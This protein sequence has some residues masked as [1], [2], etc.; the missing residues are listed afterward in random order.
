M[1]KHSKICWKTFSYKNRFARNLFLSVFLCVSLCLCGEES[2]SQDYRNPSLSPEKRAADLVSRMTL[3]EKLM[4]LQNCWDMKKLTDYRIG[5]FTLVPFEKDNSRPLE[6]YV[7]TSNAVQKKIIE[8]SRL[9]IPVI[10]HDEALHGFSKEGATCFPHSIALAATWDVDLM[11]RVAG[12]IAQESR[13]SGCRQV[14]APVINIGNDPRW[15]RTQETYGEDPYL[16]A[17][18]GATYCKAFT[19]EGIVTTPKHFV[20]N[21]GDGGRDSNPVHFSERLLREIYFPPFEACIKEGGA[22]S[23]MPSFNSLD[24]R[25]CNANRWLL[26]DIL[27]KEWGFKGFTV[28]DYDALHEIMIYHHTAANLKEAAAQALNAGLD[29]EVPETRVY[30]Q[31][32]TDAVKE[33]LVP[34]SAI[35]EAVRRRLEVKFRIGLFENPYAPDIADGIKVFNT[36]EHHSLSLQAEREAIVLLKNEKNTL[37]LRKD[38]KAVAVIGAKADVAQLGNYSRPGNGKV[39][40]LAGI[41]KAVSPSTK[42]VYEK[43]ADLVEYRLPLIP[44]EYFSHVENGKT[45]KGVKVEFFNNMELSGDPVLIRTD[46]AINF[47]VG[48]APDPKVNSDFFSVRWSG[49]LRSPVTGKLNLSITT[50]DGVR[51]FFNGRKLIESWEDRFSSTDQVSVELVK[52]RDYDFTM[53]IYENKWEAKAFLGWDYGLDTVENAKIAKAVAAAKTAGAAVIVTSIVEGEF[54]DRCDLNLPGYQ[55]KL[56]EAVTATGVPTVVVLVGGSAITMSNWLDDTPA[57]LDAWYGGDEGGTAVAE[58]LF[59]DCNPSGKLPITFPRAASQLPLVYNH[60]PSGRGYDYTFMSAVPLFPFGHGLSYTQFEYSN[61]RFSGKTIRPDG[62]VTVS[63]DVRNTGKVKGDEVVQLYL[64]DVVGSVSR[65][66]KELK[67]FRRVTLEPGE[68]RSVTFTLAPEELKMLDEK[69][70]WVVEPGE[71]LVMIGSSSEDIRQKGTFEV[72]KN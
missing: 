57:V 59:G 15:G 63:V 11:E 22:L 69:M 46:P 49:K 24:G 26:T 40:I 32:L 14:L 45:A 41:R 5:G 70:H 3:E 43:G 16:S 20:A 56:I 10:F 25:P 37:P 29:V 30:G 9:G 7:A 68:S 65:P 2:F 36:P 33:G 51:F 44:A 21:F 19:R 35:D 34:V 13:A 27:R 31:P 71:F 17:R 38:L 47:D 18:M 39:S 55:E 42:V 28:C 48:G 60:K 72:V 54:I 52:G 4:Q 61:L 67:G 23:L 64:R 62:T 8:G 66:V 6:N 58:A 1:K 50:G 12:A 53:E